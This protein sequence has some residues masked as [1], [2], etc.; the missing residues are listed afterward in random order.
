MQSFGTEIDAQACN[1]SYTFPKKAFSGAL[2]PCEFK[3]NVL[4]MLYNR[5]CLSYMWWVSTV[6]IVAAEEDITEKG[7]EGG[8]GV[9]QKEYNNIDLPSDN[10]DHT[11]KV[12][13]FKIDTIKI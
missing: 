10:D 6:V 7:T 12:Y 4:L 5:T 3:I 2:D 1:I 9:T 13:T 11:I 8:K